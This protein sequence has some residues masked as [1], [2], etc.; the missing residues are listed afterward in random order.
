MKRGSL[1]FIEK[2]LLTPTFKSFK[3]FYTN[4]SENLKSVMKQLNNRN[5]KIIQQAIDVLYYFFL[6]IESKD[7][8]IKLLLH[9]NQQNFYKFFEKHSDIIT[10]ELVDK[11]TLMIKVLESLESF[12]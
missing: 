7:K 12:G 6:D 5:T 3:T 11:K 8:S 10:E 1:I 2:I 9:A 4:Y